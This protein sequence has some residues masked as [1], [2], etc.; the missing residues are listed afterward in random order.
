MADLYPG[1]LL[2]AHEVA[3]YLRCDMQTVYRLLRAGKL[4]G[5]KSGGQWRVSE[6]ALRQFLEDGINIEVSRKSGK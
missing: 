6:D 3:A 5:S 4:I 1:G 2:K